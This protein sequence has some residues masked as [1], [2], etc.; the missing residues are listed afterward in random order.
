MI[1]QLN[2]FEWE[3]VLFVVGYFLLIFAGAIVMQRLWIRKRHTEIPFGKGVK[4]LRQPGQGQM[5]LVHKFDKDE[6]EWLAY[7]SLIPIV[8]LWPMLA[9]M[10]RFKGG[11]QV[12][13]ALTS[14]LVFGVALYLAIRILAKRL[15]EQNNRYLGAFGERFIAE[16][17]EPMNRLGWKVFHDMPAEGKRKD[18]NLDHVVVGPTGVYVIET[19][20]WRKEIGKGI[21]G[22]SVVYDGR[23][24]R[25]PRGVNNKPL[26]QVEA[27]ARW[28]QEFLKKEA[29]VDV[30]VKPV[31]TFPE[32]GVNFDLS[33]PDKRD[34]RVV[35]SSSLVKF[36]TTG[37]RPLD[38]E[39]VE[40][41]AEAIEKGCRTVAY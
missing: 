14:L 36:L 6:L 39:Q 19:K 34:T 10:K 16:C 29:K 40:R 11:G 32:W 27:N 23:N 18:F 38:S 41:I 15:D 22:A 21:A 2:S 8:A 33:A 9:A 26:D 24:L 5:E 12:A 4:L 3:T 13:W 28:L 30:F 25:G 20:T 1:A 35:I 31:L 7:A 37:Q 17:L